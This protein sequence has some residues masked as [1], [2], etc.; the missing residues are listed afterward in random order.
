[1][2][3]EEERLRPFPELLQLESDKSK[4]NQTRSCAY[5]VFQ[6][7]L[8]SC[9]QTLVAVDERE[10][11]YIRSLLLLSV[12]SMGERIQTWRRQRSMLGGFANCWTSGLEHTRCKNVTQV[13]WLKAGD[14]GGS[15]KR[16]GRLELGLKRRIGFTWEQEQL[17]QRDGRSRCVGW[18]G[19]S[20]ASNFVGLTCKVRKYL[21]KKIGKQ[22][23]GQNVEDLEYLN[24]HFIH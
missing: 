15:F 20:W 4:T 23:K 12:R 16:G 22:R 6:V 3:T 24:L 2:E 14:S 18:L 17:E 19:E 1:M 9:G 7:P 11:C 21:E 10:N 8:A 13:R 5:P